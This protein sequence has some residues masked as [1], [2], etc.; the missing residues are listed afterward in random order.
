MMLIEIM[1]NTTFDSHKHSHSDEAV[2]L[3]EGSLEYEL[4]SGELYKLSRAG[5]RSL[6]LPMGCLHRVKSGE[7]GAM[8]LEVIGGP[9]KREG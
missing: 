2:F 8:Y 7:D 4:D 3:L 1:P 9:F 5:A 6:I